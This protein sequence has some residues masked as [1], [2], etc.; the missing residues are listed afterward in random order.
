MTE[1]ERSGIPWAHDLA[2]HLGILV[3]LAALVLLCCVGCVTPTPDR[4]DAVERRDIVSTAV[5]ATLTGVAV[6]TPHPTLTA[7]PAATPT[8]SPQLPPSQ[9]PS[10]RLWVLE[11]EPQVEI[12]S[13]AA[14]TMGRLLSNPKFGDATWEALLAAQVVKIREA[15]AALREIVPPE[16][17]QEAHAMLLS[18]TGDG[19][20]G[21][22]YTLK[23]I[24]QLDPDLVYLG[25]EYM[26][27]ATAKMELFRV[28]LEAMTP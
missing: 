10:V 11:M 9:D 2:L 1:R 5:A 15:D 14:L 28:M 26:E 24:Q 8:S 25:G 12:I 17:C 23:G 18:A 6:A 21:A 13:D 20:L 3:A 16:E 19:L 4:G 7:T 22:E 27:A